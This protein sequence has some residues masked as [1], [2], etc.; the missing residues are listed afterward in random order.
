METRGSKRKSSAISPAKPTDSPN[1]QTTTP[2][3]RG[4]HKKLRFSDSVLLEGST[5][6][7]PAVGKA[8]LKTPKLRRASTPAVTRHQDHDEVQFHPYTDCLT[9]R[10]VR[11]VRRHGLSETMNQYYA[12]LKANKKLVHQLEL[13]NNEIRKLKAELAEAQHRN[14]P[15]EELSSSQ[16]RINEMEAEIEQLQQS[17]SNAGGDDDAFP[18]F[19]D[20]TA[21]DNNLHSD[22]FDP[23]MESDLETARQAKQSLFTSFRSVSNDTL[24]FDDSPIRQT[25]QSQLSS[26][27]KNHQHLSKELA[28]ATNRA[29]DAELALKALDLE[30]KSLGFSPRDYDDDPADCVATIKQHFFDMRV[31]LERIIP[32]ET[33]ASF[34]NARLIPEALAKLKLVA[35]RV[36][37]REAEL[38]SMRDERRCLKG[39]FDHAIIRAQEASNRIKELEETIDKNAEEMLEIRMRSQALEREARDHAAN[40][41]R[42]IVQIESYR[43]EV[44]KMEDLFEK[45]EAEHAATL[46]EIHAATTQHLSDMDAKVS[47]ET[48]GRRAAEESAVERLRKINDLESALTS[49]RQQAD[50]AQQHLSRLEQDL[51]SSR[52]AHTNS[53]KT[54]QEEIGGLNSRISNLSTALASADAEIEKLK[55][56]NVKLE[57]RYQAEIQHAS[58]AVDQMST[59]FTRAAA[60]FVEQRKSYIR[61]ATVRNANWQIESDDLVSDPILPMT[62]AS[63]VRFSSPEYGPVYDGDD[64]IPGSVEIGRGKAKKSSR[65]GIVPGLGIMKKPRR[66]YDSG[67]GMDSL[68]E[69]D[70]EDISNDPMTPEMSSELDV[71]NENENVNDNRMM[72]TG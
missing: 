55:H 47:A 10:T 45:T 37:E 29:E 13:K 53:N 33:I 64:H 58:R 17:F 16:I 68:S 48:R 69:A 51:E 39:N 30:I 31:E 62:P 72:V 28:A 4:P 66:R 56:L 52:Y 57:D 7:T 27:P 20:E 71:E 9:P 3:K 70:D 22:A 42:L 12:D 6:L 5:G 50:I 32:G 24:Q 15:A 11:Q 54:H 49:A 44:K 67:I 59:E 40:N 60:K 18:I 43:L 19:E 65:R 63:V 1:Y 34:E 26:P 41:Q 38:K 8:S 25:I 46:Q 2:L 14:D 21:G 35:D 23:L 36:R 61:G